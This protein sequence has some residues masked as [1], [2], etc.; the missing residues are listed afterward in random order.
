MESAEEKNLWVENTTQSEY[1]RRIFIAW[2]NLLL[3]ESWVNAAEKMLCNAM[4]D[5]FDIA[6]V[7]KPEAADKTCN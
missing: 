1:F 2:K 6:I 4:C 3:S 5:I 7:T